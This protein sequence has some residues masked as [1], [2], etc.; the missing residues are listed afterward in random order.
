MFEDT[1]RLAWLE[2]RCKWREQRR[3]E[4]GS[5]SVSFTVHSLT[6]CP[7][8]DKVVDSEMTKIRGKREPRFT[9]F[10]KHAQ[11]PCSRCVMCSVLLCGGRFGPRGMFELDWR[12]AVELLLNLSVFIDSHLCDLQRILE[13]LARLLKV[14]GRE[15]DVGLTVQHSKLGYVHPARPCFEG[16]WQR[17]GHLHR[18]LG[19]GTAF[20]FVGG[21]LVGGGGLLSC[22]LGLGP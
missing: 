10:S 4:C 22:R 11:P 7:S 3:T 1:F 19:P 15:E 2:A 14:P 18:R 13:S 5:A 21:G 8:V 17:P 20:A 6:W 16:V 9:L 12:Q